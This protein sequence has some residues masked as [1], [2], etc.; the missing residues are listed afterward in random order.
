MEEPTTWW[1]YKTD[2]FYGDAAEPTIRPCK[3]DSW[4]RKTP[5]VFPIIKKYSRCLLLGG[6]FSI[7]WE[8]NLLNPYLCQRV[9]FGKTPISA[10]R[11]PNLFDSPRASWSHF[12]PSFA[13][14]MSFP[15][16]SPLHITYSSRRLMVDQPWHNFW[17]N[18]A[19]SLNLLHP[20]TQNWPGSMGKLPLAVTLH[21]SSV[22][23]GILIWFQSHKRREPQGTMGS[24][25]FGSEFSQFSTFTHHP[26][27]G[28]FSSGSFRIAMKKYGHL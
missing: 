15:S 18:Q 17:R 8:G 23:S 26:L 12:S 20:G 14:N 25:F 21:L 16:P 13:N 28:I 9:S 3:S 7:T 4:W 11:D 22:R 6:V 10:S 24:R 19:I 2:K 27:G 1:G 5:K